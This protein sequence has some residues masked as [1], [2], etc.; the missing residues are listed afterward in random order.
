MQV[1]TAI[2]KDTF[3]D[4]TRNIIWTRSF[5]VLRDR[6]CNHLFITKACDFLYL[7]RN[8]CIG[9]SALKIQPMEAS[10]MMEAEK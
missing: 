8:G 4:L 3:E 9:K 5:L 1:K 7:D 6:L 2:I 10:F